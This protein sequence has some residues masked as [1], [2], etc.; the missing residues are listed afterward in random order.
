MYLLATRGRTWYGFFASASTC[1]T[2]ERAISATPH[3]TPVA[4]FSAFS[5][6]LVGCFKYGSCWSTL[7]LGGPCAHSH[8]AVAVARA[9]TAVAAAGAAVVVAHAEAAAAVAALELARAAR[10]LPPHA[11]AA[12]AAACAAA[13]TPPE[14]AT[15][16]PPLS[17]TLCLPTLA[18]YRRV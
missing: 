11:G 5:P 15:A 13:K 8:A 4:Q 18:L 9:A 6:S 10:R 7:P 17:V 16:A 12:A 2:G 1:G 14:R 3:P